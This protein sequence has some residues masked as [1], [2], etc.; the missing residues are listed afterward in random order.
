MCVYA[1]ACVGWC[2]QLCCG[3]VHKCVVL[4]VGLVNGAGG[5][6]MEVEPANSTSPS[7]HHTFS[8]PQDAHQTPPELSTDQIKNLLAYGKDLQALY[9]SLT[10]QTPND[11]FKVLLQVLL[12]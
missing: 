10:A 12:Y 1:R 4:Q 9:N 7:L 6:A 2:M 3:L 8:Q 11:K 5:V